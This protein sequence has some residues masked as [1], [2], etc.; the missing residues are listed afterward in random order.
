MKT[1]RIVLVLM[2]GVGLA[3]TTHAGIS[4]TVDG[5]GPTQFPGPITPPENA[6]W[7]L[8]GYPG[9]TVELNAYT[10]TLDLT[11]GTYVQKINTLKWTIDYTYAGTATDSDVWSDLSFPVVARR[12]ISIIIHNDSPS[13]TLNQSGLLG[14]QQGITTSFRF[15]MDRRRPSLAMVT[16]L[17][18]RPLHFQR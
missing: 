9:D 2:A 14:L 17:T 16:G 3:G 15:S 7:G 4:Y 5:W 11:P 8:N 13:G 10:G 6:P 1:V 18:S 12:S